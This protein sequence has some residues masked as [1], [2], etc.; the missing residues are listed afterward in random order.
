MRYKFLLVVRRGCVDY[1]VA[2]TDT[3]EKAACAARYYA[4]AMLVREP[5]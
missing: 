1:V 5:V 2:E 3:P 4:D